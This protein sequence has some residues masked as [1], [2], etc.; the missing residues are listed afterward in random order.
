MNELYEGIDDEK[1]LGKDRVIMFENDEFDF[2]EA[3]EHMAI[4]PERKILVKNS[5]NELSGIIS[6]SDIFKLIIN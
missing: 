5:E 1:P 3:L 6:L 2:K 4:S